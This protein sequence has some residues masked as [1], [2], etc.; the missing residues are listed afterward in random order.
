MTQVMLQQ[1]NPLMQQLGGIQNQE[2][3]LAQ[4]SNFLFLNR[5]LLKKY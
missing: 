3:L 1:N 2:A 5:K 4:V